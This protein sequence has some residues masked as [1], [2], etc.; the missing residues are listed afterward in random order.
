MLPSGT[1]GAG[2]LRSRPEWLAHQ[3]VSFG[4]ATA[5]TSRARAGFGLARCTSMAGHV[6]FEVVNVSV[7]GDALQ[8]VTN[9]PT[10][11]YLLSPT[12]NPHQPSPAHIPRQSAAH[13]TSQYA[14]DTSGVLDYLPGDKH[15]QIIRLPQD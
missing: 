9:L 14:I 10:L 3:P 13:L 12:T 7:T 6:A 2:W 11:Q 8:L 15:P 4:V 1:H 5:W